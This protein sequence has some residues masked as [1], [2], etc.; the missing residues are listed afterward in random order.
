[1][2]VCFISTYPPIECGIAT[3]TQYLTW[4]LRRKQLHIY[5]VSHYGGS[6]KNVFEAFDY[7]DGDL[8]NKAF[9]MITR[10]SPD[11][12][13]VQ[14]EFG[15]FG[16]QKGV[17]LTPLYLQ[18]KMVGIPVI[19]TLHTVLT[20]HTHEEKII[21]SF[22]LNYSDGVIIH[23][24]Y[25]YD[26]LKDLVSSENL[27]KVRVIPHG[28]REIKPIK[29]AKKILGIS[30]TTKV[31]LMIGYF[32]PHKGFEDIIDLWPEIVEKLKEK[33][34]DVLL[35]IAGKVR[36]VAQIEY[37]NMLFN[38]INE[39]PHRDKIRV[40]RGQISQQSFDTVIS[41]ADVVVLP[42]K[43]VSQSGVFAHCL[44]FGKPTVISNVFKND[45]LKEIEVALVSRS[46]QEYVENIIK[47]LTDKE[48][49]N[50]FSKNAIKYVKDKISWD[51]VAEKHIDFYK[52]FIEPSILK[53]K[54]IWMD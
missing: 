41:A 23:E 34:E 47:L 7:E 12:V 33:G 5:I 40:I 26:I 49:Y 28:A 53:V 9:S 50:K 14:H 18:L 20:N 43:K 52:E 13:H 27:S 48:L 3:Y 2:R 35:I 29:N 30:P 54:T 46:K 42:Y 4:A 44:A 6:G 19:T 51:K 37:G 22:L 32:A 31:I 24:S 36:T 16:K 25:Q 45:F 21:I 1:M 10:L 38:K 15:L 11:I 39:S 8:G 17:S